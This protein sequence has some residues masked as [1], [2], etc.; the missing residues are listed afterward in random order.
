M[1]DKLFKLAQKL[2]TKY[3]R[4]SDI[5]D[6]YTP[7]QDHIND[8]VK[9]FRDLDARK[10]RIEGLNNAK[11][12]INRYFRHDYDAETIK[13]FNEVLDKLI[14]QEKANPQ[15][16]GLPNKSTTKI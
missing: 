10:Y 6:P 5:T 13:A 11:H 16:V 1:N 9:V 15:P 3:D 14:E 7:N 4:G 12:Q 8:T 2:S